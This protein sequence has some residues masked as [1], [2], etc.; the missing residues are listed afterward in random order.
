[1]KERTVGAL[2]VVV[3]ALLMLLSPKPL[4]AS[5]V[6][7]LGVFIISELFKMASLEKLL[8]VSVII[9][10]LVFILSTNPI[11]VSPFFHSFLSSVLIA[12]PAF[13]F[14]S[15]F[16][17]ALIVDGKIS[18]SFI[19]T[20]G[21]LIYSIFGI[22]SL[23]LISKKEF[24]LLL[25]IVWST[26][27]FAFLT[28]K[29]FGR[30]RLIPSVSPKK[31]V[32]GSA[33]GSILGTLISYLVAVKLSVFS[34]GFQTLLLLFMLTVISQI[35]DLFESSLKRFFNVKDSGKTIPGHGGVLDRLDSTLAVAPFL[36]VISGG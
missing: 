26:D 21:F 11:V 18:E 34:Q 25:S 1:M 3:Y 7:M 28:G 32:E 10:S 14:L 9:Y 2:I 22:V 12:S 4:Y 15:L 20:L 23:S 19:P 33:G 27:T 24:I 30:R 31:T 5:L 13:L 16:S 17:Y 29:Y 8:I 35:G 36:Y 6:Y